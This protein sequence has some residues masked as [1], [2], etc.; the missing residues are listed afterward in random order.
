MFPLRDD[1]P[2]SRPP[3]VTRSI[4]VLCVLVFFSC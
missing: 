2:P 1:N 3:L 4:V